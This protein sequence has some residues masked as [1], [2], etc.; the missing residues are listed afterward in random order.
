MGSQAEPKSLRSQV[1]EIL[2]MTGWRPMNN[3]KPAHLWLLQGQG[4]RLRFWSRTGGLCCQGMKL[5]LNCAQQN[6]QQQRA[7]DCLK[8]STSSLCQVTALLLHAGRAQVLAGVICL[9][10][11][12]E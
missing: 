8:G 6:V 1:Q 2:S 3:R 10:S 7:A 9:C 4:P 12:L 5:H 11:L